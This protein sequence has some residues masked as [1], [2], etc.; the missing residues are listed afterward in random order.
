M[1]TVKNIIESVLHSFLNDNQNRKG[2]NLRSLSKLRFL[3]FPFKY[4]NFQFSFHI[5]QI[6]NNF[7][8]KK[9]LL[10][11]F[12]ND[13]SGR[14]NINIVLSRYGRQRSKIRSIYFEI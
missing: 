5:S 14:V 13:N 8:I 9:F 3:T 4:F 11:N 12:T 7:L 10:V 1:N 6:R 2:L